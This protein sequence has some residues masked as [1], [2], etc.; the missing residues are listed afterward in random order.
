MSSSTV[1]GETFK[2]NHK[3]NCADRYFI[4]LFTCECCGKLF[5]GETTREFRLRWNNY[6]CNDREYTTNEDS[7]QEHLFRHVH[8]GE[9]TVFPE[10]VKIIEKIGFFDDFGIVYIDLVVV[11]LFIN[12]PLYYFTIIRTICPTKF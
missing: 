10:N 3:L 7:F 12:L 4:Y 8:S 6:K 5:V 11:S 1:S 9:H 2:I